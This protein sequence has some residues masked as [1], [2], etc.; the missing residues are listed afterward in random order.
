LACLQGF[1]D[2]LIENGMQVFESAAMV[3]LEDHT[4]YAHAGSVTA[5]KI[6]VAVDKLTTSISP[7]ADEAFHAQTFLSVTEPLTDRELRILFPPASRCSA[8][9]PSWFIHTFV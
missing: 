8:G 2:L 4:V 5:D 6:I 7:L 9:T 1:K 3:K